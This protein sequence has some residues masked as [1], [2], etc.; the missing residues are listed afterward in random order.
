M[1]YTNVPKPLWPKFEKCVNKVMASGKD[2]EAAI[3]ICYTQLVEAPRR[4]LAVVQDAQTIEVKA[5]TEA[6]TYT[7]RHEIVAGVLQQHGL[8]EVGARHTQR[9]YQIIEQVIQLM[10]ELH[11]QIDDLNKLAGVVHEAIGAATV[12]DY[13][14]SIIHR[15]FTVEA[16]DL[17]GPRARLNKDEREFLSHA[18]GM[19][20]AAFN[21]FIDREMPAL[22]LR[23][24]YP[25]DDDAEVTPVTPAIQVNILPDDSA[26]AVPMMAAARPVAEAASPAVSRELTEGMMSHA[27]LDPAGN[28]AGI[29]VVEGR[30]LNGNVYTVA[31]LQTVP[32]VFAGAQIFVNHPTLTE[33]RE[34][35]EGD[36][37]DLVGRLPTKLEDFYIETIAEGPFS[38]RKAACF[39]NGFLSETADWLKTKIGEGLAG[40]MSIVA[41]GRGVEDEATGDFIVEAFTAGRRLDFVTRAAA[42]GLGQLA[43]SARGGGKPKTSP[44]D[45]PTPAVA[46]A[47]AAAPA[48][49]GRGDDHTSQEVNAMIEIHLSEAHKKLLR[50][51]A[52]LRKKE[53]ALRVKDADRIVGEALAGSGLPAEAQTRVRSLSEAAIRRF[54]EAADDPTPATE[55]AGTLAPAGSGLKPG[56]P[57]TVELPPDVAAL[58]EQAQSLWLEAYVE[59][60]PKGEKRAINLA[61]AAVYSDGWVEGDNG[62]YK[63]QTQQ[64][65]MSDGMPADG[66]SPALGT[67]LMAAARANAARQPL[68]EDGLKTAIAAAVKAE[69]AY[70][71]KVTGA[72]AI[73]GMGTDS[74]PEAGSGGQALA[75]AMQG[76]GLTVEQAKIAAKGR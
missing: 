31:A 60:L 5:L 27:R 4:L 45:E 48:S 51:S 19:A 72:G 8:V 69:K 47:V 66:S 11:G 55:P 56:D 67:S 20:L 53:Q 44:T 10:S 16:D 76:W 58:P 74:T 65:A 15:A 49:S 33:E 42:G 35:P 36:L 29:V 61:W 62:W 57:P 70:L 39:R 32:A 23:A 6:Q 50:Q 24:L 73:S 22:R 21:S 18:I 3:A 13:L 12:I 2:K 26:E 37:Y 1:P 25:P 30:S 34:R 71:A 38:G 43:E 52:A 75:E 59:S 28:L 41:D 40:D 54:V 17:V 63:E 46:V 14:I 68:T 7:P 9:E 64:P